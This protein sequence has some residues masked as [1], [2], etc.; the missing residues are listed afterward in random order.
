SEVRNL[1]GRSA[2]AAREIKTLILAS[3]EQVNQGTSLV[4]RAG[5]TMGNVVQSI[6][7][8]TDIMS[9]IT[10]ALQEQSD[11]V[12]QISEAVAHLDEATRQNA[13]LVQEGASAAASLRNN[14]ERLV[15]NVSVFRLP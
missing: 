15:E 4:N 13:A 2:A 9:G 11:G 8:V 5:D 3:V 14:S 1:A 7:S 12:R 6:G 10:R